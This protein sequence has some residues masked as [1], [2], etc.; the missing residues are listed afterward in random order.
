M[1]TADELRIFGIAQVCHE[2]N[3]A[4]CA[5]NSDKSQKGWWVCEQWQ[6][7]SAIA[8]VQFALANPDAPASAQHDAWM[9]AKIA[10]GWVY[11]AMKDPAYKTHPCLV[12]YEELP[13]MQRKKDALFQA[14][15]RA[16][17]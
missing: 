13:E 3:R 7:D 17:A 14:I 2:A 11:G 10:D 6:R 9:A 5:A 16:L 15:V 8:G 1:P 12:P 4:W